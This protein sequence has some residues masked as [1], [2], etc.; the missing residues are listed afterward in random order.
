MRGYSKQSFIIPWRALHNNAPTISPSKLGMD[1][2]ALSSKSA[3]SKYE[4]HLPKEWSTQKSP[5]NK[6]KLNFLI[7]LDQ[8]ES[9]Q[10]PSKNHGPRNRESSSYISPIKC[11]LSVRPSLPTQR[12]EVHALLRSSIPQHHQKLQSWKV[13]IFFSNNHTYLLP[14]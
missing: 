9:K 12:P 5:C 10:K 11:W 13:T 4:D 1:D 7:K 3:T 8:D 14:E 6:S 2:E